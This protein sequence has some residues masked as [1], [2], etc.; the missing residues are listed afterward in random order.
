MCDECHK[1]VDLISCIVQFL[2]E[3]YKNVICEAA[4]EFVSEKR[5]G[6]IT[7]ML[8]FGE[9][10]LRFSGGFTKANQFV[11]GDNSCYIIMWLLILMFSIVMAMK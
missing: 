10:K 11:F 7:A 2:L 6:F 1:V 8:H 5:R 4:V 3:G 9:A